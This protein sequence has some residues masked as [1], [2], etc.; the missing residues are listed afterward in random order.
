M[1]FKISINIFNSGIHIL[2]FQ[3]Q[4]DAFVQLLIWIDSSLVMIDG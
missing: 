4:R 3:K 2:S 1:H